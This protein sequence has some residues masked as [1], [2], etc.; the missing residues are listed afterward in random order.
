MNTDTVLLSVSEIRNAFTQY[1]ADALRDKDLMPA[2]AAIRQAE[3]IAADSNADEASLARAKEILKE[4]HKFESFP[5]ARLAEDARAVA[6]CGAAKA[7]EAPMPDIRAAKAL[8][9]RSEEEKIYRLAVLENAKTQKRAKRVMKKYAKKG[10]PPFDE[11]TLIALEKV[12]DALN[13][14]IIGAK[15]DGAAAESA[16]DTAGAAAAKKAEAY[17]VST[18]EE[19]EK[20]LKKAKKIAAVYR[21]ATKPYTDACLLLALQSAYAG[22]EKIAARCEGAVARQKGFEHDMP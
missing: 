17:A 13:R 20:Q 15:A 8:P 18:L 5:Y 11:N 7:A 19:T 9:H 12:R 10:L 22:Y 3:A 16:G 2:I 14:D 4:I 6:A 21:T 1:A